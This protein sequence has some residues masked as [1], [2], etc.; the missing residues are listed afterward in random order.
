MKSMDT[1]V[2]ICCAGMG[3][4]LGIGTTKSLVSIN[5]KPIIYYLINN[6]KEYDDIRI[7]VGFQAQQLI[8]TVTRYRKDITFVF[9]HDYKNTKQGESL[10]KAL[11]GTRKYI[12][13]IEG[14][15]LINNNHFNSLK[16]IESEFIAYTERKSQEGIPVMIDDELIKKFNVEDSKYEWSGI[17]YIEKSKITKAD[18]YLYEML[19]C[20]LPLRGVKVESIGIDTPSDYDKAVNWAITNIRNL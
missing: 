3:T 15:V 14:D 5:D 1:T 17:S 4:R 13:V 7:V 20:L 16:K 19:D 12:L 11:V 8:D 10:S 6:L 2:V 18:I 9:N